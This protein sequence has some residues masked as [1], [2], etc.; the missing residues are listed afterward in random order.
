[1]THCGTTSAPC[2]TFG[3][4]SALRTRLGGRVGLIGAF[5]ARAFFP[6]LVGRALAAERFSGGRGR[7]F[8]LATTS[9]L[10]FPVRAT[11]SV[12]H[13]SNGVGLHAP[14]PQRTPAGLA[15][16]TDAIAVCLS[17]GRA[18]LDA[19]SFQ[20]P[21]SGFRT[22]TFGAL[23]VAVTLREDVLALARDV[24]LHLRVSPA[25]GGQNP[26]TARVQTNKSLRA[27][28]GVRLTRAAL[29]PDLADVLDALDG[30]PRLVHRDLETVARHRRRGPS[31]LR[32]RGEDFVRDQPR[33]VQVERGGFLG[34][35]AL[36]LD[37]AGA[38]LRRWEVY[39]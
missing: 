39:G 35:G 30:Q 2:T 10:R 6:L 7:T 24:P 38:R 29:A 14:R 26:P 33:V 11:G 36:L 21:V 5:S 31:L 37:A 19:I 13:A 18:P 4:T 28:L 9:R 16:A 17:G 32:V 8:R 23:E 25:R 15:D 1:M 3:T 27:N 22:L 20:L 12:P 34:T